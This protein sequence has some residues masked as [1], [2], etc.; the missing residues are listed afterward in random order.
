MNTDRGIIFRN[1]STLNL[2]VILPFWGMAVYLGELK[3]IYFFAGFV[4]LIL[5][6]LFSPLSISVSHFGITNHSLLRGWSFKWD[7]IRC[8]S[9]ADIGDGKYTIHFRAKRKVYK[10][11]RNVFRENNIDS[12]KDYFER[13]CGRQSASVENFNKVSD[14]PNY[15]KQ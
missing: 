10:I 5:L 3:F 14:L 4:G 7:D 9:I 12:L 13:Y 6:I 2:F 11:S 1:Y 8:W 15:N